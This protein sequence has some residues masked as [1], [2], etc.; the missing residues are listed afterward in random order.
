MLRTKDKYYWSDALYLAKGR[1]E[2]IEVSPSD[3]LY[4]CGN[5]SSLFKFTDRWLRIKP[6]EQFQL[7]KQFGAP[8]V[9]LETMESIRENGNRKLFQC[10]SCKSFWWNESNSWNKADDEVVEKENV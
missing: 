1:E 7:A 6:F 10:R 9:R 8:G 4:R 2:I 5:C 3:G